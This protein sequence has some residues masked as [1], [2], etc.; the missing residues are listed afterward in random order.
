MA[1]ACSTTVAGETAFDCA[2][3]RT[4]R[5][6]HELGEFEEQDWLVGEEFR[7]DRESGQVEGEKISTRKASPENIRIL[8]FGVSDPRGR[9]NWVSFWYV[10]GA[11]QSP[12]YRLAI[13]EYTEIDG[14]HPFS[15]SW[16]DY[17]NTGFCE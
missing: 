11:G 4:F 2:V 3:E 1:L 6:N 5:L 7:V 8:N 10:I 12:S 17:L 14:R 13:E 15:L 9:N 16:G